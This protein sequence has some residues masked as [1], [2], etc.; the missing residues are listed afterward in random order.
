MSARE[1][2]AFAVVEATAAGRHLNEVMRCLVAASLRVRKNE[3]SDTIIEASKDAIEEL[4]G[5]ATSIYRGLEGVQ[6]KLH[7]G[8]Q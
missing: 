4:I 5:R 3:D 8:T 2:L 6:R 7:S 1:D